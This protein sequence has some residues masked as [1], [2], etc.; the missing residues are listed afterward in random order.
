[1]R[2]VGFEP[3]MCD[4]GWRTIT[5]LKITTD[6]GLVGW[7]ECSEGFGSPGLTGVVSALGPLVLGKDPLAVEA[8]TF[9]LA[10]MT[11][12]AHGSLTRQAIAAVENALLDVKGKA[13][14][15]PVSSL[16]GGAVRD[17]IPV[18]WSH[19]GTYRVGERV[20]SLGLEPLRTFD[21]V[22]ALGKLVAERGFR[23]L[24][25]NPLGL[26]DPEIRSRPYSFARGLYADREWDNRTIRESEKVLAAFRE[27]A[28]EDMDI[29][30]DTNFRFDTQG[31]LRIEQAV[32]PYGL[33]WLELDMHDPEAVALVRKR[34]QTPIGSGEAVYERKGYR[35]FFEAQAFDVA[36]VD[37]VW[38]GYLESLK[39][40][41]LA[42]SFSVPVAPHN[43]YGHLASAISA[44][45]SAAVPNLHVME[46]DIDG[47]SWRDE[48]TTP[49]VFE[50]GRYVLPTGPGWGV[51][52]NEEAIRAHAPKAS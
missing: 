15:L 42:E 4:L 44:H 49:P 48:L 39:I 19:C 47:A 51:E 40:A 7:S 9:P 52:V 14:G 43:F 38:N 10:S 25:T 29:Y 13:L 32:R 46:I 17:R 18:Y 33:A 28:G 23:G 27:G 36:I 50:D 22:V 37:V 11:Q 5:F 35:P 2:V 31:Y 26:D 41:A 8:V 16:L 30:L 21:D 20:Q 6:E 45:F 3:M 12:P 24:K 1:M 34:A